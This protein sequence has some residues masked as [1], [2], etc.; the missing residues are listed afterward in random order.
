[1]HI[2]KVT[3]RN[4][5]LLADVELAL[6]KDSTVIVGRNN[7][8][9]TSAAEVVRRFLMDS[10]LTFQIEDFSNVSYD[11]FCE[12]LKAKNDGKEDVEIRS[13]LPSIE[14]KLFFRY[15]N[16][17]PLGPLS[18]FVIDLEP[19]SDEA[20]IVV[21]YELRAGGIDAFFEGQPAAPLTPE[22]RV[23]FF[24]ALRERIPGHFETLL[25]A[26]DPS[27]Q[28]NRK[29]LPH[30]ALRPL[31]KT[32]FV[33]AQRGLDDVTYKE[34]DVLAKVLE[35]LFTTAQSPTARAE[36]RAIAEGLQ[37][38]VRT[39]QVGI[40]TDF[41]G[42]LKQ[43]LPTFAEFGYPGLGGPEI[44][45]ETTLDVKRLLSNHTKVR[46]EGYS[47]VPLPEAYNGLG[48][49]NLIFILLQIVGF[50]K[51]YRADPKAA[52]VHLVFIEEPEAHLHPQMQ[53]VFIRQLLFIAQKLNAQQ[54]DAEPWPVQFVVSTHSSH[55]ANEAGFESIRY[56][57]S[58]QADTAAG[59]RQTKIKDFRQ[60]LKTTTPDDKKFLHQYLTLTRCDL[61]FADKAILV[62]GLSERLMLP[63]II[64]KL[65][66]AD[67]KAPKLS[68]QYTTVMEVGGAYA[69]IFFEL[70]DF[71]ELRSLIITDIDSV[72]KPGGSACEVHKGGAT[73]NACL[74]S[75]F[76]GSDMSI[77]GLLA[78]TEAEKLCRKRRIAFQ[79]PEVVKGP[80][81]RTFEDA[82][83][84][85]NGVTFGVAGST[86]D[87]LEA[88]AMALAS[89]VKKSEF[90]LKYA[91]KETIWVAPR[92]LVDGV[93]WL[94]AIDISGTANPALVHA[95]AGATAPVPDPAISAP[96]AKMVAKPTLKASAKPAAAQPVVKV[97]QKVKK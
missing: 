94:A 54:P 55:V 41:N 51:S 68:S 21:R 24:R 1:M 25:W 50:Y 89:K 16:A 15:D 23:K 6:E 20:L 83:M 26:E 44:Q 9:K 87:E 48:A 85:A 18:E 37:D 52:G 12:A 28:S 67:P 30:T 66:D 34:T 45:T 11:G 70:L 38:A 39:I 53:E 82:F 56:F 49:R 84:L 59:V 92:Y 19:A 95:A 80:C 5:R 73:S 97:V 74:K 77:T 58:T 10:K 72:E 4:F 91:I 86:S 96:V 46:Y 62:E 88:S 63:T 42:K 35:S 60:G 43:L 36:D 65:E 40:D 27:D 17:I 8:G 64:K 71:L 31:L 47:G 14:L 76:D 81:G 93:K 75:W 69:H 79:H 3:I 33:N 29:V 2:H 78:K 22:S 61:F 13:L 7:S 32:G 90:A 57:L